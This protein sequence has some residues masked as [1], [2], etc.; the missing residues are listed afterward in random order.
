MT[1]AVRHVTAL[2]LT[3]AALLGCARRNPNE[4][5]VRRTFHKDQKFYVIAEGNGVRYTLSCDEGPA[6][7]C[8]N[9]PCYYVE[10]GTK[11]IRDDLSAVSHD[12]VMTFKDQSPHSQVYKIESTEPD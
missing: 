10:A 6:A 1:T 3:S 7:I 2:L 9:P 11:L 12:A 4:I 8:S 5:V